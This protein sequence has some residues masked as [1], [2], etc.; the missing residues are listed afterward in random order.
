LET[1]TVKL[2]SSDT[3]GCADTTFYLYKVLFKGL[4]VP[5]AF[6]PT[7]S[8]L[9]IRL[10]QPV[11]ANLGL[12]HVQV[13]DSWGHLMWESTALDDKGVP[14]EGWDGTFEGNLM[15]QGNYLW[16]INARFKDDSQWG[17]SDIGVGTSTGTM[18]TVVLIR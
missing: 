2:I 13:F 15:P 9:G 8:I 16:K 10:F 18:G 5:N 4:Y 11:G 6:S 12:Y 7:S 14:T 1:Y 3:I 17:G